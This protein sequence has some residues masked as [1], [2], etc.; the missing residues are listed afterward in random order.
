MDYSKRNR[1]IQK[2]VLATALMG[3][4]GVLRCTEQSTLPVK[5]ASNDGIQKTETNARFKP[6]RIGWNAVKIAGGLYMVWATKNCM[7]SLKP[8]VDCLQP[9]K[10]DN[11]SPTE[12]KGEGS[13]P[14]DWMGISV[15]YACF[16]YAQLE[17]WMET[18]N[19][20]T[21]QP[22]KKKVAHLPSIERPPYKTIV[23]IAAYLI[24]NGCRGIYRE[25]KDSKTAQGR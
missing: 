13:N 6:V 9:D 24:Y 19:D 21:T 7:I 16:A 12:E 20:A 4:T 17:K 22:K 3:S 1:L 25:L 5:R 8:H 2:I 23:A 18:P 11:S 14:P 10:D 15:E